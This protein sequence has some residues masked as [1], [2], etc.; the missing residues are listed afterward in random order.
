MILGRLSHVL[1]MSLQELGESLELSLVF[2]RMNLT[3]ICVA[4]Q[5]PFK[6][7]E[8]AVL[9]NSFFR[10]THTN[11]NINQIALTYWEGLWV[12]EHMVAT[13]FSLRVISQVLQTFVS[14]IL[15]F[16]SPSRIAGFTVSF[17]ILLFSL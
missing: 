16:Y 5:G 11:H 9:E 17:E 8:L 6:K 13:L 7:I 14:R 4:L 12:Y 15:L 2:P 1:V 10:P 3:V